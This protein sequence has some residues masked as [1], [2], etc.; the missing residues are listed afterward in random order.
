MLFMA[1]NILS[2]F[3][4]ECGKL[5]T[6]KTKEQIFSNMRELSPRFMLL[7]LVQ[8]SSVFSLTLTLFLSYY[9]A[10]VI[11]CQLFGNH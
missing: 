8:N 4:D 1:E 9:E 3:A 6:L 10:N 2:T 5:K 7:T 11:L